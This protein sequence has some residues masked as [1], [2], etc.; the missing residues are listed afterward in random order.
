[1]RPHGTQEQLERRRRRAIELLGKGSKVPAI[2]KKLKCSTSSVYTWQKQYRQQGEEGLSSKEVAGRPSKLNERQRRELVEILLQ[3]AMKSGYATQLWT[4]G[5]IGEVIKRR[6]KVEYHP[7][8]VWN[9]LT[10]MGW[11]CQK[12]EKVARQKNEEEVGNWK[13]YRWPH[14]KKRP[15]K[16]GPS[17]VS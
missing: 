17:G 9:L 8:S 16:K 2:A 4:T 7:K 3:G 13:K 5:R 11:S 1:M 15:E 12:P 6:L 10:S 14:I